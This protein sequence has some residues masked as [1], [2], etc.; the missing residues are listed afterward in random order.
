MEFAAGM[1]V[2]VIGLGRS[3]L[4]AAEVLSAR[5]VRVAATDEK[6]PRVLAAAIET[7]RGY[8]AR[9]VEPRDLDMLLGQIDVAVLSPGVPL[10]GLLMQRITGANVPVIGEIEVAFR[11]CRA[12][13][14]AVSG[15]KGKST[16]TAL[17]G[18]LLRSAGKTV[19]VGG[20]IGNPLIR[21]VGD[22]QPSDWVVA[23][24]SSFQLE[25]IRTF[26]PRISVL[27]NLSADHLDRYES[28]DHYV[29]AKLR[30]FENQDGGDTF[31]GNLADDRVF[32]LFDRVAG[33]KRL[34]FT[35]GPH[36]EFASLYIRE[37]EVWSARHP[38]D[39]RSQAV[40]K[41][42]EIPLLG[43]HNVQ[44]A[45]AAMLVA[46]AAGVDV[47]ALRSG[48]MS[49]KTMAHRLQTVAEIDGVRFIDDSKA[50]NPGA[51]IAALRAF[52]TPVILIAGGK[53]KGTDFKEMGQV[54]SSRTKTVVLIGEAA[55]QISQTVKGPVTQRASSMDEAVARAHR[56]ARPGDV[57]LLS[58]GCASFD[59][60][61]SAEHRGEMF[62][63]AV[64][65]LREPAG[66]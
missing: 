14:I 57:I 19:H 3:G 18:H 4:A 65:A 44:N 42:S 16:T 29:A 2:L 64:H 35:D 34:W 26:K 13:L 12:P 58:P 7:L 47:H 17:I 5:G 55:T 32:A 21:E 51:V 45:L 24:V 50:T 39:G 49:F 31:V 20:N 1:R 43:D 27:L 60:F 56:W 11:L 37:D 15:T 46:L 10:A 38:G 66:A 25:T 59:M 61:D 8:G 33:P 54:I 48:V 28:M 53:S 6:E 52:E 40:L 22:A 62:A 9:F 41:R 36:E 63:K 23:E 30:I